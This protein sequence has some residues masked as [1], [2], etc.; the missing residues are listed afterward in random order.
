MVSSKATSGRR[1]TLRP[2]FHRRPVGVKAPDRDA[3]V[4]HPRPAARTLLGI[5]ACVQDP[6][7]VLGYRFLHRRCGY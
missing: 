2:T 3:L 6:A 5:Q 1:K 4:V 7:L